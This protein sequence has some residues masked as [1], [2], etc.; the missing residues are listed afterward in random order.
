MRPTTLRLLTEVGV[1]RGIRCVDVGC[2]GG[3]VALDIARL[4]GP[5]GRVTGIDS[6]PKI[7]ELARQDVTAAAAGNVELHAGDVRSFDG[8]PFDLAY[9][10]F[11]FSHVSEPDA[12]FAHV[13]KLVA[14]GGRIVIEEIDMSGSFCY[15][16]DAAHDQF[17]ELY[18]EVVRRG[19]GDANLGRRMPA[20]ALAAGLSGVRW[21]VFQPVF[22]D[23]PGKQM[24][25]VTMDRIRSAALSHGLSTDAESGAILARLRAF[26]AD[27]G[28]LVALP[29]MV[30]VWG[31]V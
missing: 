11:L 16:P 25:A 19:G 6:D 9:A 4:I 24:T 14:P 28:T 12:A 8:G 26:A 30:Q 27:P 7:I 5:D 17:V 13:R 29:R 3:H 20:M 18:V 1:S 21:N 22:A 10:R 23:G 31:R 2:G 15:P